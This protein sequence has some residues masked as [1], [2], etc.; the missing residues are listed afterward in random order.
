MKFLT[1][2]ASFCKLGSDNICE[3]KHCKWSDCLDGWGAAETLLFLTAR[4]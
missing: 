3:T 4:P 1:K 2:L